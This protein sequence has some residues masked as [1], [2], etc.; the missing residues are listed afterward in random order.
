MR[1]VVVDLVDIEVALNSEERL[2]YKKA[3]LS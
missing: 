1:S 3:E 2:V